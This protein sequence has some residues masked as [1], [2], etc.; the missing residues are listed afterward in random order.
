MTDRLIELPRPPAP[1]PLDAPL[2]PFSSMRALRRNPIETWTKAH[3]EWP[4][5]VGPTILGMIA[6]VNDP[7]AIRRV[8]VDNAAN[9][10]KDALQKR[11]L[12]QG[13]I[14]GLAEVEGDN[15][16]VQRRTLAPLFTPKTVSSFARAIAAA[17]EV[18]VARWLRLRDGRIIDIRPEMAR[19]TLDVLGRT[20]FSDGLGQ[21]VDQFVAAT[22]G[23]FATFG[24]LDLFDLLDFPEWLPRLSKLGYRSAETFLASVVETIIA[25]RKRLL[26]K[27]KAGAPRDLLT[28][29]LEAQDPQTGAGLSNTEVK[30][31]I[32]T[33][34]AA[35][36]ETTANALT[37]SLFLLTL[38]EEWRARLTAEASEVL[39]GPVE[40]YAARLV[41]TKAVIE[42]AMRLYPPVT[43][44]SRQAIGP[45]DLAGKRIRKGSLVVVSQWVLHRH[46]LLWD[47]PDCFDPRRFLP[48]SREKID[49]F[50]YL[51]FGAGPRVCI[52]ASFSLQ[53]AAII[54]AHITRSFS[55]ELKKNH[56]LKPVQR[57]TLKPEGG[58]PM[59][60][61]RRRNRCSAPV[62]ET[63]SHWITLG[64][65]KDLNVAMALAARNAIKFL[66]TR[67]RMTE[68]DAYA[69]CSIGVS[70][71][72][73]QVVDI[74]RGVHAL[75]PKNIFASELRQQMKMV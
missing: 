54:L 61:R 19:V 67:A 45:D 4:I 9:Y 17:A 40:D 16:R 65:D 73:T 14:D 10:R 1:R 56:V 24:R 2:G 13:L 53:A 23:Y 55:L 27:D 69:L 25:K 33:F 44:L 43:S 46:R 72:V 41:E 8:F 29:L 47:K 30:A 66:S 71:R 48:G 3:F 52:G 34:I 68:L 58:L 59:I 12:G 50:A 22:S 15:W 42:E 36:H 64:L 18:L 63:A 35:G 70:F 28:L 37:W 5:L 75:I 62:A 38:S 26:V 39:S 74:V 57:I 31:N 51:P 20:I 7:A 11:I 6:V 60:L 32:L 21:D 49:R